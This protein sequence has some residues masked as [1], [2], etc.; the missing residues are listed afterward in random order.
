METSLPESSCKTD[1]LS[2][3]E[4]VSCRDSRRESEAETE[5]RISPNGSTLLRRRNGIAAPHSCQSKT[6]ALLLLLLWSSVRV[7]RPLLSNQSEEATKGC[8]MFELLALVWSP[9]LLWLVSMDPG[10]PPLATA[11][12]EAGLLACN[13]CMSEANPSLKHC[14]RCEKCV[15]GFDHH[16]LWLNTCIG[17]RNYAPWL[18]FIHLMLLWTSLG[19]AL[20]WRAF[21][22]V[23][24]VQLR[25]LPVG[26]RPLLLSSAVMGA[27]AS[28]FLFA[29][30][31]LHAYLN[32][33]GLTTFE[34]I[35][36]KPGKTRCHGGAMTCY[37]LQSPCAGGI[38]VPTVI[39]YN[40]LFFGTAI[41]NP[42]Q[43]AVPPSQEP[44]PVLLDSAGVQPEE[45][46]DLDEEEDELAE[47]MGGS[48][49]SSRQH[50]EAAGGTGEM[51]M[52][53][54]WTTAGA[55]GVRLR[56][57]SDL[58]GS[59]LERTLSETGCAEVSTM[60]MPTSAFLNTRRRR[61]IQRK[62]SW[63]GVSADR[64]KALAQSEDLRSFVSG[65]SVDAHDVIDMLP[66]KPP[67]KPRARWEATSM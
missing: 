36:G 39:R 38:R 40:S 53:R 25:A 42:Q 8:N 21:C 9:L 14:K 34:W 54:C 30:V 44:A 3:D 62:K 65:S 31:G 15:S 41:R 50:T 16:C 51:P 32:W 19:S 67:V 2:L 20:S 5:L 58:S 6:T 60:S 11:D 7:S 43:V 24:R 66:P 35:K 18:L 52:G 63:L 13:K 46:I 47:E 4:T 12:K 61:P 56:T 28:F 26:T 55:E 45:D 49:P 10:E 23:L 33:N 57:F 1:A 64:L 59:D 37:A 27:V 22:S 29:L 17:K 48:F